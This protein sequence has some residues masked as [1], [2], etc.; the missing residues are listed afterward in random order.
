MELQRRKRRWLFIPATFDR[1]HYFRS[2]QTLDNREKALGCHINDPSTG[3]AQGNDLYSVLQ[4]LVTSP[5]R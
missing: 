3:M 2:L 5:E 1:P 4:N